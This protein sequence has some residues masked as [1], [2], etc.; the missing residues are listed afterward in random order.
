MEYALGARDPTYHCL[1]ATLGGF[2]PLPH[3]APGRT[4]T[5]ERLE[6]GVCTH[7]ILGQGLVAAVP[8]WR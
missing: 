6:L 8:I 4:W 5:Q 2:L 7:S 3:S 1:L